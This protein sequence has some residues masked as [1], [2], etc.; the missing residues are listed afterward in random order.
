[1]SSQMA[2]QKKIVQVAAAF[3]IKE[4]R[5][6]LCRRADGSFRGRW[7]LP[8]GKIEPGESP[9]EACRRELYEELNL[10]PEQLNY[11]T[12]FSYAYDSFTLHMQIFSGPLPQG[13]EL[14]LKVHDAA[15]FAAAEELA[16]LD[17][18]PADRVVIP[19]L[20]QALRQARS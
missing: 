12:E 20:Q 8:G 11:L 3:L 5:G 4:G 6:L 16:W 14:L 19:D 7:E 15:V 13:Q 2:E 17:I 1:M 9:L 18:I 10:R